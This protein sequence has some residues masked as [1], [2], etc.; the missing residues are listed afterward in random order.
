MGE[1]IQREK[2]LLYGADNE[3]EEEKLTPVKKKLIWEFH[4]AF[5]FRGDGSK[6]LGGITKT[7]MLPGSDK[8]GMFLLA[9]RMNHACNSAQNA[10][11]VWRAD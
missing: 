9:C 1:E 6:S 7:N 5:D 8:Q 10:R 2:P 3:V 11:Y 4:D